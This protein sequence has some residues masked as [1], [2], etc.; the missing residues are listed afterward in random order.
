M[1]QMSES[2]GE[3]FSGVRGSE[4]PLCQDERTPSPPLC[5]VLLGSLWLSSHCSSSSPPWGV[6]LSNSVS[7]L[8]RTAVDFRYDPMPCTVLFIQNR[9]SGWTDWIQAAT[10]WWNWSDWCRCLVPGWGLGL[11][12]LMDWLVIA[13]EGGVVVSGIMDLVCGVEP[14]LHQRAAGSRS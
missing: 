5:L 4:A 6:P 7:A 8:T 13:P 12:I 2:E 11:G 14:L 3:G 1:R 10:G 9:E